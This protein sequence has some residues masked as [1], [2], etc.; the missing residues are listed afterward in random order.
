MKIT[1]AELA[2]LLNATL[3]GDPQATVSRPA[4]IEE[5]G[6]GDFSFFDNPKYEA[7]VYTTQASVLLVNKEFQPSKPVKPTLLRVADVRGSLAF[8]L[9]QFQAVQS[10]NS[11]AVSD[12]AAIDASATLGAGVSI[13]DFAVV[14]AGVDI[15]E[16]CVIGAQV[17]I[18]KNTRIGRN[19]RIFPGAKIHHECVIGDNC[20]L[21]ANAVIGADGFGFAPQPDRSWKKV[22]QV[23]NVVL[24]NDV[25]IGA[26]TCIDRAAIGSTVIRAGAKIDNL[27][28]VAH[29]VEVGRNT[30]MAAQ[31]GIAGS[32][33]VGENVVL[34]GQVG[35]A[36]HLHIA[37]GTQLQAQSGVGS[38]IKTPGQALFGSPAIPYNDYVRAYVVFK[39][40]PELQKKVRELEKRL[41]QLGSRQD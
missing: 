28:H 39:Q 29:N 9:S 35:L 11:G 3:E 13:G 23:G 36:G 41:E 32:T 27:V 37:D 8:L 40:L 31:V 7:Q 38:S 1:A 22:P 20:V 12:R 25:E 19:C 30:V 17:F 33:K 10:S 24:E 15:G 14:E 2:Q 18:G 4:R 5:A 16:G 26:N 21:H 34:G 6:E